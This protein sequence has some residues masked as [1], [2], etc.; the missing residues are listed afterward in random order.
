MVT[1][2]KGND[3]KILSAESSLLGILLA[4]GWVKKEIEKP[5]KKEIE[6]GKTSTTGN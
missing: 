3:V 6:N 4:D 2:T 1:F 5:A